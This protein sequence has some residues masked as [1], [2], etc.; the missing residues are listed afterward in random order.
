MR[1][2]TMVKTTTQNILNKFGLYVTSRFC[3]LENER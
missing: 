3:K 1:V 2:A